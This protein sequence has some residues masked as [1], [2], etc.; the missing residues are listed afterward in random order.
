MAKP[1]IDRDAAIVRAIEVA[2]K[3]NGAPLGV[4]ADVFATACVL[5]AVRHPEW[6][7]AIAMSVDDDEIARIADALVEASPV[8]SM[9]DAG[10]A[11]ACRQGARRP[12]G[13]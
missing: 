10:T 9:E 13:C 12:P 2:L 11:R 3:G 1:T 6:A 5:A 8:R 7:A 4:G